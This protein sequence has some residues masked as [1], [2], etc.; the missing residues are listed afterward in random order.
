MSFEAHVGRV[1]NPK[2]FTNPDETI[3]PYYNI[4]RVKPAATTLATVGDM[5]IISSHRLGRGRIC[6]LNASKLFTLYREDREGGLLSSMICGLAA[7]AL[8][9]ASAVL[10]VTDVLFGRGTA[11]L[12]AGG[13][14]AL[15]AGLWLVLPLW[16]SRRGGRRPPG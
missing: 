3:S 7:L 13:L 4:V 1:F 5:P 9:M 2:A 10:L 16:R 11:W 8:A 15:M 12:T 14:S 6:L